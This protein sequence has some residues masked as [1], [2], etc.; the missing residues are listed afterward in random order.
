MDETR[1]VDVYGAADIAPGTMVGVQVDN[2]DILLVNLDGE[3][4][5]MQGL[6][7]HEYYNLEEGQISGDI[8]TCALHASQF[9]L[10]DGSV[11]RGPAG[12]PLITYPVEIEGGRV[13]LRLPVGSIPVNE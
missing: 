5:A 2:V 13:R 4:R 11:V 6:C 1:I 7:S 8:L 9:D 10:R 12:L 3:I